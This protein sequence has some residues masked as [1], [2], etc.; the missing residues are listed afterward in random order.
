MK[1]LYLFIV[2]LIVLNASTAFAGTL[3]NCT[4]LVPKDSNTSDGQEP[5]AIQVAL[6]GSQAMVNSKGGFP[7]ELIFNPNYKPTNAKHANFKQYVGADE[8][9]SKYLNFVFEGDNYFK[10]SLL[11]SPSFSMSSGGMVVAAYHSDQNG[12]YAT[13]SCTSPKTVRMLAFEN[14][15]QPVFRGKLVNPYACKWDPQQSSAQD[16]RKFV[17]TVTV[18]SLTSDSMIITDGVWKKNTF[19]KRRGPK[20]GGYYQADARQLNSIFTVLND[21]GVVNGADDSFN[22]FAAV[23]SE[24]SNGIKLTVYSM[25]HSKKGVAVYHCIQ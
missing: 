10:A 13:Y 15:P 14:P 23:E 8:N 25:K 21:Q 17:E 20:F 12:L 9:V 4:K 2:S 11:F 22:A 7:L 3:F 16:N 19:M 6:N 5:A 1:S 24:S 18:S